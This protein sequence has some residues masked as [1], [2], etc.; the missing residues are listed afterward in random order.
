MEIKEEYDGFPIIKIDQWT[1]KKPT[2][3]VP[4]VIYLKDINM[5]THVFMEVNP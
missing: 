4:K 5:K 3:Q 1:K 2:P